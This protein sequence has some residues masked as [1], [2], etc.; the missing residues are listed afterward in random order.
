M[1]T[2]FLLVGLAIALALTA[3]SPQP[4]S[5]AQSTAPVVVEIKFRSASL[6]LS[7][8]AV[9][10]YA[11]EIDTLVNLYVGLVDIDRTDTT[12]IIPALAESWDMINN[13][14]TYI[15]HLREDVYWVRYNASTHQTERLRVVDAHD[16]VY[17]VYRVCSD[18]DNGYYATDVVGPWIV[19][20]SLGQDGADPA[21]VV[22]VKALDDFT[23]EFQLTEE[24][25]LFQSIATLWT[26]FPVAREEY[27]GNGGLITNGPYVWG[28]NNTLIRNPYFP[29]ELWAGG[30]IDQV[31]VRGETS[32]TWAARTRYIPTDADPN[33]VFSIPSFVRYMGFSVDRPPLDN[34]HVRRALATSISRE[35]YV[36][37]P[38]YGSGAEP[39]YHFAP[40]Q[41]FGGLPSTAVGVGYNLDYARAE[42]AAAG[43]PNCVGLPAIY[44]QSSNLD[45]LR[46]QWAAL[47]CAADQILAGGVAPTIG[48]KSAR[49]LLPEQRA[50]VFDANGFAPDYND[51][52]NYMDIIECGPNN[53]LNRPCSEID[54]KIRQARIS[55]DPAER[56]A[57]YRE[58]QED[59]FGVEGDFPLIPLTLPFD[60]WY[61]QP[62]FHGPHGSNGAVHGERFDYYTVDTALREQ[63][64]AQVPTVAA[65][66]S[67]GGGTTPVTPATPRPTLDPNAPPLPDFDLGAATCRL[68]TLYR[69]ALRNAPAQTAEVVRYVD[70]GVVLDGVARAV[71]A[72]G[73]D[74]WQVADGGWV[75]GLVVRE[76][77][78]CFGLPVVVD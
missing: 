49:R 9:A 73:A 4:R 45:Y 13:G 23:V 78:V 6:A 10:S 43:Y 41:L 57:L 7:D 18:Y 16:V 75:N 62:W 28:R 32:Q 12:R 27:E 77:T 74:W 46:Q 37:N 61:V 50:H 54:S 59:L 3:L 64:G 21:R 68:L 40:E 25:L 30:N 2:R 17:S 56:M 69:V 55:T 47:G 63:M 48:N 39:L 19:G 15:F 14:R 44:V 1:F 29:D 36:Q 20:C 65:P 58:L 38:D 60:R 66:S 42:L 22:Q 72:D 24:G 67:G 52:D 26:L 76:A 5:H 53:T 8:P 11:H 51:V 34:V 33:L 35:P 71:D 31:I 70:Y